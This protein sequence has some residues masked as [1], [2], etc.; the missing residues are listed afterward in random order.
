[1]NLIECVPNVSEGTQTA[2]V[3]ALAAELRSLGG[4]ALLDYSSDR[5]HNRSVFTLAGEARD[6]HDAVMI[7]ANWAVSLIDLRTHRGEH[8]RIG[9]LDVVP[10]VPL[11]D[12][13]MAACVTLARAVGRDVAERF[14]VPVYLYEEA[15]SSASRRRLEDIRRGQFEGLRSRMA[16]ADWA[17]D[18]GPPWPHPTAGVTVVG[19][20][21]PL[22][23]YNV[24]LATKRIE[25]ARRI[26]SAIRERDG[27][28]PGV[29]AMGVNLRERGI[30]Q[31]S[32]NLT[33]FPRTPVRMV[34][35][36]IVEEAARD[37]VGVIESE[38]V[39]LIPQAALAGTTPEHLRLTSF[40]DRQ[41]LEV[42]L[43]A[44]GFMV[45]SDRPVA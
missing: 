43:R 14:G 34:F 10:F 20:R 8:P 16:E 7:V 2:A 27:G 31:V 13:P 21:R 38:L 30:V 15:S 3:D 22:V 24:N 5:S 25:V 42:Q 9:A 17:P 45:S 39:G 41:I 28:L 29:K 32:M 4:V 18:F 33:D 12:T 37:G 6:L 23:A 36:R 1:M 19:A 26:A 40:S 44:H 11:G 35:D